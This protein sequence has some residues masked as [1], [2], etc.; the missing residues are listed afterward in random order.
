M[1]NLQKGACEV[2]EKQS[3]LEMNEN[4][5]ELVPPLKQKKPRRTSKRFIATKKGEGE[6]EKETLKTQS[7]GVK[8]VKMENQKTVLIHLTWTPG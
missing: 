8:Y 3:G 6:R 7:V 5:V 4:E 2:K 1:K